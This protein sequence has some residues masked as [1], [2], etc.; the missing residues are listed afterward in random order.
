VIVGALQGGPGSRNPGARVC[1]NT[2]ET[3]YV[4]LAEKHR[5]TQKPRFNVASNQVLKTIT[6]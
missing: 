2:A 5:E 6:S 1:N 4:R 3:R